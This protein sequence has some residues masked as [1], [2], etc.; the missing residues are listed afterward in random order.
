VKPYEEPITE[1]LILTDADIVA[2][3]ADDDAEMPE[4]PGP[5]S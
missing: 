3:S 5:K 1:I 4:L 2:G